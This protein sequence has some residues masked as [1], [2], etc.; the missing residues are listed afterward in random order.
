MRRPQDS[1]QPHKTT[2]TRQTN[3]YG[4]ST[5][6][7]VDEC[8]RMTFSSDSVR[9]LTEPPWVTARPVVPVAATGTRPARALNGLLLAS[10]V[11]PTE[12]RRGAA[13]LDEELAGDAAATATM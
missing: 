6:R 12:L 4:F 7:P 2:T 9:V 13:R 3:E 8:G 1:Y 11:A 5:A 10:L